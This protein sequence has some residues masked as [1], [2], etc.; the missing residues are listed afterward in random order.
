MENDNFFNHENHL[1]ETGI[2]LYVDAIKLQR[3]SGLPESIRHH[4]KECIDCKMQILE[5][6]ALLESQPYDTT[7]PHPYLD[8]KRTNI[9]TLSFAYRA[10]AV[11]IIAA[12]VGTLYFSF[13]ST[14]IQTPPIISQQV[15]VES[16]FV[17]KQPLSQQPNQNLIATNFDQSP[18]LDD[19]VQS[20][21][22]SETIEVISPAI[23]DVVAPPIT[24]RWKNVSKP[25][26]ITILSNKELVL[27]RSSV[28]GSSF[29]TNRKFAPGL[30]YW[31]LETETELLFVGKFLVR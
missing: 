24:F 21:F 13:R 19:L 20:E 9:F 8:A 4:V 31:K 14:P 23:G 28:K 1:S 15:V 12:F 25:L 18:N 27:A 16:T 29:T 2:A 6:S 26:T 3:L 10:A 7:I 22:R 17:E 30:Y 5:V 11:L